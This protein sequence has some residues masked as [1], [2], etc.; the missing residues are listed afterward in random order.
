MGEISVWHLGGRFPI[1]SYLSG[2]ALELSVGIELLAVELLPLKIENTDMKYAICNETFGD[3]PLE[4]A[5]DLAAATGYTGWEVAPF[6][7][8]EDIHHFSPG[9]RF[10]Y[11]RTV[12]ASGL[13]IIGLHWLLARTE[14]LH[15]TTMDTDV[16]RATANYLTTLVNLCA[17]LGGNLMVLGSPQ[18]RNVAEGQSMESAMQNAAGVLQAVVPEL[19]KTGVRIAI[20]PLGRAEGNFLNTAADVRA[21]MSM[22]D[23]DH[24]QLHLDVKAMSD[25]SAPIDQII[26]DN[27][28][29]MIHFHANDPNLLGPGMGKVDFVP[30]LAALRETEYRGWVSVEV[31]DYS[32]GVETLVTTSMANMLAAQARVQ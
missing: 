9:R 14:G 23:S 24:V 32:P 12:E 18:Q 26:R 25:E 13:Q 27:A 30:I 5:L 8:A 10:A 2:Q 21:L 7:P 28:D 4:K 15:L 22:V 20:E 11:A 31:F 3:W 16:R 17:D 1:L 19:E 6:M 29:A